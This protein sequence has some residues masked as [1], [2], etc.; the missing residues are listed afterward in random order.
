MIKCL[1]SLTKKCGQTILDQIDNSFYWIET[2]NDKNGI[3]FFSKIKIVNKD[4]PIMIASHEIID[5]NYLSKNNGIRLKLNNSLKEIKFGEV[6]YLNKSLNLSV[7][8]IN[9][10][11]NSE[12]KFLE[13]DDCL[14]EKDSE[15]F[16]DKESIYIINYN[17]NKNISISFGIIDDIHNSEIIYLSNSDLM[18]ENSPIFNITNNKL[19]GLYKSNLINYNKGL[20]FKFIIK[21]FINE[22]KYTNKLLRF[23]RKKNEINIL[24]N[25]NKKDI[26]KDIY[27]LNHNR[28]FDFRTLKLIYYNN[29]S[30]ELNDLNTELYIND[31]K[32]D[33]TN[34]FKPESEGKYI[35]K[36]KFNIN[37]KDCS[38]MFYKCEKIKNIEFISFN[39]KYVTNMKYMFYQCKQLTNINLFS[40]ITK[41]VTDMSYMFFDCHN[42]NNIDLSSFDTQNVE[43]MMA[44]FFGCNNLKNLNLSSFNIQN[45]NE[46]SYIFSNCWK[47]K[48]I[49]FNSVY[50]N[51]ELINKY[52]YHQVFNEINI[53]VNVEEEDVNKRVYFLNNYE[54]PFPVIDENNNLKDLN[55]KNAELYIDDIRYEY[56]RYFEPKKEGQ[57]IIKLIFN[58]NL[59]DCSYMFAGCDLIKS[60]YFISFNTQNVIDMKFMFYGCSGL[61]EINLSALDTKNVTDMSGLFLG[62]TELRDLDFSSFNTKNVKDM[63][64][65]FYGCNFISQLDLS[66]FDTQKVKDMRKMFSECYY[67]TDL[68][69]SSFDTKNVID[70]SDMFSDCNNLKS[71]DLSSF[72][73]KNV[74]NMRNMFKNCS[75]LESLDLSSF[76]TKN[77]KEINSIFNECSKEIIDS[78]RSKFKNFKYE[79]MV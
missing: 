73:T 49:F 57:Y 62:C 19:I 60:I 58:I 65:M 71:L 20:F 64:N 56:K 6:K 48:N 7:V 11:I 54:K 10:N 42:L 74:K 79:D 34:Y 27:F 4:I 70:M 31:K 68:D 66:P 46:M 78:N 25:I 12:I 51:Q 40:F 55:Y 36:L 47:L 8:E 33:F 5:E 39:T 59:I 22:Y 21:E 1:K 35:I 30:N 17:D 29:Q 52:E 18:A 44:M 32:K 26:N 23:D 50:G 67:L 9:N 28:Y 72:N 37:L 63:S 14:Y 41:N 13:L 16:Y 43:N 76:D 53:L 77:V 24:F 61:I 75:S 15:M 3:C 38:Y 45:V 69:L 2:E